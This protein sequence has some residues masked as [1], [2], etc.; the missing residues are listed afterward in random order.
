MVG[1]FATGATSITFYI[2]YSLWFVSEVIGAWFIPRL[3]ERGAI[4][5]KRDRG[6]GALIFLSIFAAI[7]VA[8]SF[9]YRGVAGLPDWAFY[10]GIFL[11]LLGV[12]VRQWSIAVLGRFFSLT[13]RVSEDHKVVNKGPYRL[14]R[15]PSYTG[16]LITFIGLGLAVQS[17]GALLVLMVFF[18]MAYGY[19]IR[20]EEGAL[21]SELGQDY[22]NY[23]KQTKR[24]IPYLI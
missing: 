7:S 19:R 11:I 22:M 17:W 8:L 18:G 9:G 13:V 2:V 1:L 6:S 20:I 24:L 15:H 14:V 5:V 10:P 16:A 23:V 12:L 21:V 4:R 3:R